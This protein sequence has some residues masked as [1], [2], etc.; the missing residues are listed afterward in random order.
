MTEEKSTDEKTVRKTTRKTATKTVKKTVRKKAEKLDLDTF[1]VSAT[2]LGYILGLAT[3]NINNMVQNGNAVKDADGKFNLRDTVS[4]YCK[5]LR[6][7]KAGDGK[8]KTDIDIETS[9]WKLDNIKQ[10]NRDWRMQRDRE[11]ALEITRTLTNAMNELRE[12]AKMNPAL[13]EEIDRMLE[14]IASVNVD[15]VSL[16]VEGEDTEDEE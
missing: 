16:A 15:S 11:V 4:G 12:K 5:R 10:K 8:S 7:K 2:E 14:A 9:A 6:D 3:S 1:T 13:V